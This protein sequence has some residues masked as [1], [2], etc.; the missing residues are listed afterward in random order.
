MISCV[1]LV[2]AVLAGQT[3]RKQFNDRVMMVAKGATGKDP[4]S[5]PKEWRE[6]L[7]QGKN[8]PKQPS[9]TPLKPTYAELIPSAYNPVFLPVGFM[10]RTQTTTN[11]YVDL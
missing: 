3:A 7:A 6:A 8:S 11:T 1:L 5:T 10:S 9:Q 2:S 4:G